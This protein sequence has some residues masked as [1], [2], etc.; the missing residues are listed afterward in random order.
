MEGE[1]PQKGRKIR[2]GLE[3]DF[4]LGMDRSVRSVVELIATLMVVDAIIFA[5][6]SCARGGRGYGFYKSYTGI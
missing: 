3:F 5:Q 1:P 4:D 6:N 2:V